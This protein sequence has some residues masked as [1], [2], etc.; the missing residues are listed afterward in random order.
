[1]KLDFQFGK[2]KP[3]QKQLI[4]TAVIL[5]IGVTTVASF[6]AVDQ[7]VIWCELDRYQR[8]LFPDTVIN[9]ILSGM[10]EVQSCRA[11]DAV[12]A[13][14]EEYEKQT[15]GKQ[16]KILPPLYS[17]EAPDGSEAQRLLGGAMRL[18]SPWMDGCSGIPLD[19]Y[20]EDRLEFNIDTEKQNKIIFFRL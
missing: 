14:L 16:I 20:K 18:C 8:K 13:A 4:V 5:S 6:F 19:K 3:N 7:K 1:M 2:K 17:E 9:D 15:G 10:D 12:D 11:K